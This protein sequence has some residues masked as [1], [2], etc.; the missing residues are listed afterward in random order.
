MKQAK[1]IYQKIKKR[2]YNQPYPH[3]INDKYP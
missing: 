1:Y 3:D 2:L